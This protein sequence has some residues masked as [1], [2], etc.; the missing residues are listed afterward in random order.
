MLS[1][2]PNET[3]GGN[4]AI[5]AA[6][7]QWRKTNA[8]SPG[9]L[10]PSAVASTIALIG[11]WVWR[12]VAITSRCGIDTA[13]AWELTTALAPDKMLR[14]FSGCEVVYM[15]DVRSVAYATSLAVLFV[16]FILAVRRERK[17]QA[18][19]WAH[20]DLLESQSESTRE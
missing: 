16:A 7:E 3:V 6:R 20:V 14:T 17:A 5:L 9:W 1:A 4:D 19:L 10:V 13:H 11:L 12:V 8:R 18:I 2:D 15:E